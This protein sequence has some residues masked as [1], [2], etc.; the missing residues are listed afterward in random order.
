MG[1]PDFRFW[2]II[3]RIWFCAKNSKNLIVTFWVSTFYLHPD[4]L[5]GVVGLLYRSVFVVWTAE[6]D[7]RFWERCWDITLIAQEQ[8]FHIPVSLLCIFFFVLVCIFCFAAMDDGFWFFSLDRIL[9]QLWTGSWE[10]RRPTWT[11]GHF[12]GFCYWLDFLVL[13]LM[14]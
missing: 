5:A 2:P 8:A 6:S 4:R 10:T 14:W 12:F 13:I 9:F 1:S 7:E 11:G 3:T